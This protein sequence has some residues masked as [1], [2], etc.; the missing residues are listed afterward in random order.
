MEPP[1]PQLP[2]PPS[3]GDPAGHGRWTVS[4]S[5]QAGLGA[6]ARS[7]QVFRRCLECREGFVPGRA[8]TAAGSLK[9]AQGQV[10][11]RA[12]GQPG[13]A[14]DVRFFFF[15]TE[16]IL[17]ITDSFLRQVFV[18]SCLYFYCIYLLLLLLQV[19]SWLPH[20]TAFSSLG[21]WLWLH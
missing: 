6:G 19:V 18:S 3:L 12:G 2:L 5:L 21:Q 11:G 10:P 9:P 4:Y 15:Y 1:S 16:K 14:S 7:V 17:F 13:P 20:L 8:L